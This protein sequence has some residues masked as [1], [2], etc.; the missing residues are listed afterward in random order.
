VTFRNTRLLMLHAR[1]TDPLSAHISAARAEGGR[2][3]NEEKIRAFLEEQGGTYTSRE[4]AAAL[5]MEYVTVSPL[6]RPMARKGLVSNMGLKKN[7]DTNSWAI[8]W[9]IGDGTPELFPALPTGPPQKLKL[10]LFEKEEVIRLL[11]SINQ[12]GDQ[13]Q[14]L[15][16]ALNA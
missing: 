10:R 11:Q 13:V 3:H 9:G 1:N 2:Q 5:G 16:D 8:A 15:T 12:A 4:I 7:L 6:M 14:N